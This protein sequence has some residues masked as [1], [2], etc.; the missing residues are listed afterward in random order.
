MKKNEYIIAS[1]KVRISHA[2]DILQFVHT[3]EEFG[4]SVQEYNFVM[5]KLRSAQ[6]A[7][8]QLLNAAMQEA[9]EKQF[10]FKL[11][12][13][14]V[15]HA[16]TF[17]GKCDSLEQS[18]TWREAKMMSQPFLYVIRVAETSDHR[19]DYTL[20]QFKDRKSGDH[21]AEG[22]FTLYAVPAVPAPKQEKVEAQTLTGR[23]KA[24]DK[25]TPHS[26]TIGYTNGL[27]DSKVWDEAQCKGQPYLFVLR[28]NGYCRE[29]VRGYTL[30]V[31]MKRNTGDFFAEEDFNLYQEGDK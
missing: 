22:D 13:K 26:K 2:I 17:F 24:G 10:A 14:V 9:E 29:E 8:A 15:P 1:N 12:D 4:I 31:D 5:D 11:G 7:V 28:D 18:A 3:G 20:S 27:Q 19:A 21:F 23:F 25:V 16:K 30:G 6:S